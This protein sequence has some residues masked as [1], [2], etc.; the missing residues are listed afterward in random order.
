MKDFPWEENTLGLETAGDLPTA[1]TYPQ[2][3]PRALQAQTRG[4]C[5]KTISALVRCFP[6]SVSRNVRTHQ[7]IN[8]L[9]LLSEG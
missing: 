3:P 4:P 8:P 2:H 6:P 1:H 5:P 7:P 9:P